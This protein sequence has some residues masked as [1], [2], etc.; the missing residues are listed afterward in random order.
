MKKFLVILIA[1]LICALVTFACINVYKNQTSKTPNIPEIANSGE[2][3]IENEVK[4][5]AIFTKASQGLIHF[6]R[7]SRSTEKMAVRLTSATTA[8]FLQFQITTG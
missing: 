8:V 2:N 3:N 1:V 7:R 5:E 6:V 4:S